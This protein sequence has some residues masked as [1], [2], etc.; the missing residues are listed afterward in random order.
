M[1]TSN[2]IKTRDMD[3]AILDL[4]L[5]S[6]KHGELTKHVKWNLYIPASLWDRVAVNDTT[7]YVAD[8]KSMLLFNPEADPGEL[9]ASI[10][11]IK[12]FIEIKGH[13]KQEENGS[14][15]ESH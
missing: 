12:R 8:T 5:K 15:N 10:E 2:R 6:L 14:L 4:I 7:N 11:M 1:E 3:E 13:K 9:L